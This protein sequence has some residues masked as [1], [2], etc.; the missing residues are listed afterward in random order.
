MVYRVRQLT[1][2]RRFS[3]KETLHPNEPTPDASQNPMFLISKKIVAVSAAIILIAAWFTSGYLENVYV[4]Y[5][6]TPNP[7]E[8]LM[9]AYAVKGIV[10]YISEKQ[11]SFLTW[12][13]WIEIGAGM[14]VVLVILLHRGDPFK[15]KN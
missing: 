1:L 2:W 6:R 10:V 13:R 14:I 4:N 15:S 7:Q 9:V 3:L 11:Q 12:L 8:G 5:P